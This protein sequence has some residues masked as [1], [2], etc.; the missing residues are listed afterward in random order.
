MSSS[1]EPSDRWR[2]NSALRAYSKAETIN[3]AQGY[4]KAKAREP[5]PDT[6]PIPP[7]KG[8]VEPGS[9]W[10]AGLISL[11]GILLAVG[12]LVGAVVGMVRG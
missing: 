12:W 6:L 7:T 1:Q 10:W 11:L 4:F 8:I 9:L 3:R 5:L 2:I